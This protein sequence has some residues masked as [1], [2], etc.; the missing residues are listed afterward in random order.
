MWGQGKRIKVA[1][2]RINSSIQNGGLEIPD[3]QQ[4]NHKLLSNTT[5]MA[6]HD[7]LTPNGPLNTMEQTTK[8]ILHRSNID[9]IS[10]PTECGEGEIQLDNV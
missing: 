10:S 3:M 2:N 4:M 6:I 7:A 1:K 9:N 5:I 8:L